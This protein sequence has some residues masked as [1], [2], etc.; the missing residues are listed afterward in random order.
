[1]KIIGSLRDS[2][3]VQKRIIKKLEEAKSKDKQGRVGF[4]SGP[5]FSNGPLRVVRNYRQL[6]KYARHIRE[7]VDFPVFSA[8]DFISRAA[9]MKLTSQ[10]YHTGEFWK[11][12]IGSGFVTDIYM[13]PN[14]EKSK[15]ARSEHE[16]AKEC[17]IKINYLKHFGSDGFQQTLDPGRLTA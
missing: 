9:L 13:A 7:S 16:A 5:F 14:W 11:K 3:E 6:R 1:M 8:I 2:D 10:N 12:I 17:G 15:G 4:V